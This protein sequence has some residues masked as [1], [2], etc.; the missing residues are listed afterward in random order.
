M[1][2]VSI[3]LKDEY[4]KDELRNQILE[5]INDICKY[6]L[7][8]YYMPLNYRIVDNIPYTKNGKVDFMTLKK[9]S[10][11]YLKLNTEKNKINVKVIPYIDRNY[12]YSNT[13][14]IRKCFITLFFIYMIYFL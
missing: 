7:F 2:V 6:K 10:Q 13:K 12:L 3:V 1:P 14:L 5:E 8:E 4:N 9:E 11:E